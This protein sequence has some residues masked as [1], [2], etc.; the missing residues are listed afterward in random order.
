MTIIVCKKAPAVN[1]Y[2]AKA[3]NMVKDCP[4]HKTIERESNT[5]FWDNVASTG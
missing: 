3:T 4:I 1:P 5:A 2:V